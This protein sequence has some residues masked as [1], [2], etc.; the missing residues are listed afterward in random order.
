MY[1]FAATKLE[2]FE[3]GKINRR[4]LIR[5]LTAAATATGAVGA[6]NGAQGAAQQV[7]VTPALVNHVSYTCANFRQAAD[8]YSK[9]FNLE[10]VGLKDTE[11]TLPFNKMG[12]Q[13]MGVT[14]KDVPPTF[15]LLRTRD[16]N[17]PLANGQ[18]RPKATN[19]VN[20]MA[21]T[22]A[23]FD[24]E[25]VQAQLRAMGVQNIRAAGPNAIHMNDAFGYDVEICGLSN[26]ALTDGA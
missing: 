16:A 9:V 18:P 12:E 5:S 1:G 7:G 11:V 21:Y 20:H 19:V 25:R 4:Q 24:S 10:Q 13:P 17:A 15:L 3:Q 6:A 14:A 26:N 2:E 22:V 23:D 8:W